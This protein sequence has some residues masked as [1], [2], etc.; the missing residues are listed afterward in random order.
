MLQLLILC[1]CIGYAQNFNSTPVT[2]IP[3]II[4]FK[5]GQP[6]VHLD[7]INYNPSTRGAYAGYPTTIR[8]FLRDE[9]WSNWGV[10]FEIR[11][12]EDFDASNGIQWSI[13][14]TNNDGGYYRTAMKVFPAPGK[15]TAT[16][17]LKLIN[18]NGSQAYS[19][20]KQYELYVAPMPTFLY[21]DQDGNKL[22]FLSGYDNIYD[23]PTFLVEG[24]DPDNGNTPAINYSLGADLIE[25][26]R[27]SGYDIFIMEYSNGGLNLATNREVFLGACRFLHSLLGTTEA[28][29]QVVGISM[30]GTIARFGLAWAEDDGLNT[31]PGQHI[32]HYVNT[33]IS[34]DSPQQGAHLN[35]GMQEYIQE[36]GNQ[37]QLSIL[38]SVA[39]QQMLYNNIFGTLHNDFYNNRLRVLHNTEQPYGYTNG[40]PKRCTNLTVSNGN[41]NAVYPNLTTNDDLATLSIYPT[42]DVLDFFTFP[43]PRIQEH[44]RA[45][46]RDLWPG[47]TFPHDLTTLSTHGTRF[48]GRGWAAPIWI[49]AY[50][51]WRF[52]VHWNP[53]YTPTESS[54]DLDGYTRTANGSLIGGTSWFDG[55]LEQDASYRHEELTNDSRVQVMNWLNTHRTDPYLGR[56]TNITAEANL[57]QIIVRFV[58]QAAFEQG[59]KV[60]RRLE[61]GP[62]TEIATLPQNTTQFIEPVDNLQP[63]KTYYYRIRSY[64][65]TKSSTFS[66]EV[67]AVAQA[68]L[69]SNTSVA[70]GSNSHRKVVS[71]EGITHMVYE[72]GGSIWYTRS[73]GSTWSNERRLSMTG[74]ARSGSIATTLVNGTDTYVHTAWEENDPANPNYWAVKYN[75]SSDGG[76]TWQEPPR[77]IGS[78]H[79]GMA[80]PVLCGNNERCAVYWKTET[81][82]WGNIEPRLFGTVH[83]FPVTDPT[84]RDLSATPNGITS[85]GRHE[86]LI[87]YVQGPPTGGKVYVARV[88]YAGLYYPVLYAATNVSGE[89]SWM[90]DCAH[91][92]I[93]AANSRIL[94]AWDANAFTERNETQPGLAP[95]FIRHALVRE[96]NGTQWT[97]VREFEH[98][99]HTGRSPSIGLDLRPGVNKFNL[100]WECGNH[101]ARSSRS[102]TGTQWSTLGDLGQGYAPNTTQIVSQTTQRAYGIWTSGTTAPFG[103]VTN[104]FDD[105][106]FPE[107]EIDRM[108]EVD[109]GDPA[110]SMTGGVTGKLI[111]R[112]PKFEVVRGSTR[113]RVAYRAENGNCS[114]WMETV[115]FNV[116]T[117]ADSLSGSV[118]IS[119]RDFHLLDSN[120]PLST[121]VLSV[122]IN[123]NNQR[124]G[125]RTLTLRDL[126]GWRTT[127]TVVTLRHTAPARNLRGKTISVQQRMYGQES[128]IVPLWSEVVSSGAGSF[129]QLTELLPQQAT[130]HTVPATFAL[131]PNYPN[132]FN[133]STRLGF[134][135]PE[136]GTVQLTVF[137]VLGRKIRDLA[138]EHYE[139]GSY[140]VVWDGT[141]EDSMPVSSGVY[142]ARL[143]VTGN[144]GEAVFSDARK[145]IMMK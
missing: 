138:A 126:V 1:G 5:L 26:A 8:L 36:H 74:R 35:M 144:T 78:N 110:A 92:S 33:F 79:A 30:G 102:F 109:L 65:G 87:S 120:T 95:R 39:A 140:S 127:D 54:L 62:Y 72:S 136:A 128:G 40:Y 47:S 141:S 143:T 84:A 3:P 114:D 89:Y 37:T 77:V 107:A 24:F 103:I 122:A 133:P 124:Y 28:A 121:P 98:L 20:Q 86:F 129:V 104:P 32:E 69:S 64:S 31:H 131:H 11:W 96:W 118:V 14:E 119:L 113:T 38:Q 67:S 88:Q 97:P 21:T 117:N 112:A 42:I 82:L 9:Q 99:T 135:L 101:I 132:P 145:L 27:N 93:V 52:D 6:L 18:S 100:V 66:Q 85:Q 34:F 2:F 22:F 76:I 63:L 46:S 56:P 61:N 80:S 94:I 125:M 15:Y 105:M 43:Q 25:L 23:K 81:G 17:E 59:F 7:L 111:I 83:P 57:D 13:W 134:D 130:Q 58:D 91:T 12:D 51:S 41:H 90:T 60:E 19:R 139:P 55:T 71:S 10:F 68:H 44:I 137:D 123:V 48:V 115:S 29:V 70:T 50:A 53:S 116:P 142:I 73:T 16:F 108:A 75:Y 45:E 106:T 4:E 49:D